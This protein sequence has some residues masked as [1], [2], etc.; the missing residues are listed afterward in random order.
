MRKTNAATASG[1]A[2]SS[3]E[4]KIIIT[5]QQSRFHVDADDAPTSKE[6]FIKDLN[7]GIGN[8]ELLSHTVVHLQEGGR[9]VLVGRNGTGKSSK[10]TPCSL[11]LYV[12]VLSVQN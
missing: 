12:L 3:S 2:S 6:I 10:F 8:N 1:D 7:I 9:Y 4:P 5:A 11:S